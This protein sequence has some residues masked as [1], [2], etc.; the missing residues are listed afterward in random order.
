M[1]LRMRAGISGNFKQRLEQVWESHLQLRFQC[2]DQDK[3]SHTPNEVLE[4]VD[5]PGLFVKAV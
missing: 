4:I 3:N 2:Q 5:S 1:Q